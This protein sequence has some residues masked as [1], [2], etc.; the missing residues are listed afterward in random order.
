MGKT[1]RSVSETKVIFE[2]FVAS[3]A[4]RDQS[5]DFPDWLAKRLRQE[6]PD[7][8][9]KA[10]K[11]LCGEIIE[12]V[13]A[14]DQA[15]SD[16]N[17]AIESGQSK[18]EWLAERIVEAAADM[19][20][21]SAGKSLSRV[22]DDLDASNAALMDEIEEIEGTPEQSTSVDEA[23]TTEWNEYSIKSKALDI[24]KQAAMS[25]LGVA[26]D[27]IKSNIEGGET[28]DVNEAIGQALKSGL[29]TAKG[30]VKAVVA[31]AIKTAAEKGL[32]DIL[33]SDTPTETIC[34]MAGAAVEGADALLGAAMGEI[35]LTEALDKTGRATVAAGCRYA[36]K[37]LKGAVMAIP[38]VGPFIAWAADG[39][40]KHI[41][42]PN[43]AQNVYTVVHDA[44]KATWEGIKEKA[45]SIKN[46]VKNFFKELL[47]S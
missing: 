5:V 26:A 20:P 34:D 4:E 43:F 7:M 40:F 10:S 30:E 38:Y 21:D 28:V 31:G 14:Y 29:E 25:G 36:A 33:P 11:K 39:L 9:D 12:G 37:A 16:L 35:P 1:D 22:Y 42:G 24:G 44:A 13:K 32:S 23:V 15:L 47:H 6:M 3:Y 41:E 19:P 2:R 8:A 17:A 46:G 18:E 45:R 27:I